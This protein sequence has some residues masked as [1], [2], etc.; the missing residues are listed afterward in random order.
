MP[1]L[2]LPSWP[3]SMS[4]AIAPI[5]R[6][7]TGD[8]SPTIN[9]QGASSNGVSEKGGPR[10]C[11][12]PPVSGTCAAW[13]CRPVGWPQVTPRNPA[14]EAPRPPWPPRLPS[15]GPYRKCQF[16]PQS[17]HWRLLIAREPSSHWLQKPPGRLQLANLDVQKTLVV[18]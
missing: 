18:Y 13:V 4:R 8:D 14:S 5:W 6:Q 16:L 2:S 3:K 17:P 9:T 15:G 10:M 12:S 1:E 11:T 7:D